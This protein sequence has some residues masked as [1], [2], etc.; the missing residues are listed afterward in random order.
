[1]TKET[2]PEQPIPIP[3]ESLSEDALNGVLDDFILR[4]GTDYG[5]YEYSLE[6]KRE[7]VKELLRKKK[8]EIVF[9]VESETCTLVVR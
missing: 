6:E 7:K 9:E 2:S 8:A 1:M 3:Y 5:P 4:E